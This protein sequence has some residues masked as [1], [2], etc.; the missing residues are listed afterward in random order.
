MVTLRKLGD[1]FHVLELDAVQFP[2]SRNRDV[3]ETV[4]CR[5]STFHFAY[6]TRLET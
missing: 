2:A 3:V 6:Y 5:Q 1:G 4:D